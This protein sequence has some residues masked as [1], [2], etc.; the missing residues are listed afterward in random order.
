MKKLIALVFSLYIIS[1][2]TARQ[3]FATTVFEDNFNS[4]PDNAFPGKW[5]MFSPAPVPGCSAT[6][7]VVGGEFGVYIPPQAGCADNVIPLDSFWPNQLND[8]VFEVDARF[9]SGT[10]HNIPYIV[11][12]DFVTPAS[13]TIYELH[14]G[15]PGDF[16]LGGPIDQVITSL[17]QGYP[18]GSTYHL[19]IIVK[20]N[21]VTIFI[22]NVLVREVTLSSPLPFGRIGLRA[23]VGSDPSGETWFDNVKVTTDGDETLGVPLIKQAD[24]LWANNIYDNAFTW[25]PGSKSIGTWGCALT[26]AVMVFRHNGITKTPTGEDLTPGTVNSWLQ[27]SVDGYVRNGLLNWLALT[28]LSRLAKITNILSFDALE[29]KRINHRD[30][31]L[32]ASS[33]GKNIP[34]ILEEP[35]HFIVATGTDSA[36]TTFFIN[37]PYY[38]RTSLAGPYNKNYLTMGTYT[39]VNSDLSYI[40]LVV[41][42]N[43]NLSVTDQNNIPVGESF[44]QSAISDPLGLTINTKGPLKIYYYPKPT[45]GKYSVVL[46]TSGKSP[47]QLDEY[48]YDK[49]GNVFKKT[50]SGNLN[51]TKDTFIIN[52]DKSDS[53]NT[54]TE[55][56][57][58][59]YIKKEI[60]AAYKLKK[61]KNVGIYT[62]LIG[63]IDI[64]KKSKNKNFTHSALD[65]MLLII[66]KDKKNIDPN[67]A[68]ALTSDIQSLK[69]SL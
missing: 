30:D 22:N 46:S 69:N 59:D 47:Y 60:I 24:P 53:T 15:S 1:L 33:L 27:G 8:Y 10:D 34:P 45:S 64:A 39:P 41:D 51:G 57:T 50:E 12:P 25:T 16:D 56:I 48:L 42:P 9:V 67:V 66:S 62:A 35:G 44:V 63:Q 38:D 58:F 21:H 18:N 4:T 23:G 61:I 68:S 37:D 19:K 3:S 17:S 7:K 31:N 43:I 55:K 6:W 29:Y 36:N 14:F 32:L 49:N 5:T 20:P 52:F 26:S 13:S 65:S 54:K 28:R 11:K 2:F 40:M